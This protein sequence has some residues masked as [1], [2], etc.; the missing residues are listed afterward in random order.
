M[1]AKKLATILMASTLALAPVGCGSQEETYYFT[2]PRP[3]IYENCD[4]YLVLKSMGKTTI[5]IGTYKEKSKVYVPDWPDTRRVPYT[6][7]KWQTLCGKYYYKDYWE[8]NSGNVYRSKDPF[9]QRKG[10]YAE[11]IV[12]PEKYQEEERCTSCK[13]RM[14]V[15]S[16]DAEGL[17]F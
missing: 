9:F 12:L 14:Y 2:P 7:T 15:D 4:H 10:T 11:Y 1:K 8:V 17:E 6:E 16:D 3:L 5:H 13:N